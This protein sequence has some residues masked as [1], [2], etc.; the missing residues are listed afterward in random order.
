[1][2]AGEKPK[3][4]EGRF[5]WAENL[6]RL[7][8]MGILFQEMATA[9]AADQPKEEETYKEELHDL[10]QELAEANCLACP[11]YALCWQ[12]RFYHTYQE[13]FTVFSWAE[14]GVEVKSTHLKGSLAKECVKKEALLQTVNLLM[15]Q[16]RTTHYWRR[17]FTEAK[18]FLARRLA[19]VAEV[20]TK[21]AATGDG[22]ME[23]PLT[24]QGKLGKTLRKAG[25]SGA[26]V[27]L[28]PARPEG[29][30]RLLVEKKTCAGVQECRLVVAPLLS[31]ALGQQLAVTHWECGRDGKGKCLF[32]LGPE[33]VYA[34]DSAVV[35]LAKPGN[36]VSGDSQRMR[37]IGDHLFLCLLSDGMGVG[38]AAAR[39]SQTA[40]GLMDE[41][42]AVGFK[43]KFA[44]ESLNDLLLLAT[45]EEDFATLDLL[46]FDRLSGEIELY[47]VGSAPTYVKKGREVQVIRSTSLPVGIV[48]KVEPEYYRDF[49]D[50]GD[51]VVMVSDGASNLGT[52]G[53]DW[54]LKALKRAGVSAAEPLSQYLAELAKIEAGG[55][56]NDDL[57]ILVLQIKAVTTALD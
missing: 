37:M 12:E 40:V 56:I 47:K 17:R 8:E 33:P 1:V 16:E 51:L 38:T 23:D 3:V 42:L 26:K 57:T 21:M 11:K 7:R 13:L 19:G 53:D 22:R 55:E 25:V 31:T 49:L 34:V 43:K 2:N 15:E 27:S 24:I 32:A 18:Y 14:L 44:L 48:P 4:D 28:F 20:L 30:A 46:L 39:I 54:L 35:Q 6:N 10:F 50:D 36:E 41:M 29:G 52:L 45:P 5:L 9:F